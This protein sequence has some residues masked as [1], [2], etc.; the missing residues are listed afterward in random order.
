MSNEHA[1]KF[2]VVTN[3]EEQY[4]IWPSGKA[5]PA[6]WSAAGKDGSKEECL[7]YIRDTWSDMRPSS[8]RKAMEG[9]S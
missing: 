6:G 2:V 9:N 3:Q 1:E 8:L 4:S 7:A 5:M